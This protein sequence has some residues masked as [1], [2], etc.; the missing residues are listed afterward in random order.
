MHFNDCNSILKSG[1]Y[2]VRNCPTAQA[3]SF[4]VDTTVLKE[5]ETVNETA[6]TITAPVTADPEPT[7]GV[8]TENV[9]ALKLANGKNEST[10]IVDSPGLAPYPASLALAQHHLHSPCSHCLA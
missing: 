1:K 9:A 10:V 5:V 4:T 6:A 7:V 8:V 3:I 2:Y